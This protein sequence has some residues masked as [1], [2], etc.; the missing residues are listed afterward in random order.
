M[1]WLLF[2]DESGHDH[3]HLPYEV[4]GG[5]ALH[6]S[7]LWPFIQ[8]VRTLE[9]SKFG[10]FLHDYGSEIK[11][12][13]LLSK[14]R[15]RW[16]K[17]GE[18]FD[19]QA[20]RKHALNFLNATSQGRTP[21]REEFT[22]YGQACI[23]VAEGICLLLKSHDAVLFASMIPP[24]KAPADVDAEVPRKDIVFLLERYFYFLR[25]RNETGLLVLDQTEK[26]NDRKLTRR[27]E[28]YFTDTMK[29]LQRAQWLVPSPLFVESDMAYGVQVADFCIY[30]LN[31]AYRFGEMTAPK[32]P[33]IEPFV[34]LLE[35]LIWR[36]EVS[37]G[38]ERY[39]THSVTYV[40]DPYTSRDPKR[41]KEVRP[42]G[43][44]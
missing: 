6:A 4:H 2:L 20:L 16:E 22:A 36:G 23:Q 34:W 11:G 31:L 1:S 28:R 10:A 17:Q 40:P 19:D 7:K 27:M 21:K 30:C 12:S 44:P 38:G 15:F 26:Q 43:P 14:D 41:K 37:R 8:A 13:K 35:P 25:E 32:R 42:S 9:Q 39:R 24:T 33:E 3:K 29:G 5:I 18:R